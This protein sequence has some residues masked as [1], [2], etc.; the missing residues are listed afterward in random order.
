M[1]TLG[2]ESLRKFSPIVTTALA[3]SH[4][5]VPIIEEVSTS[6]QRHAFVDFAWE[7]NAPDANWC[8]PLKFDALD[9]IN[10][11]K[12]PF[13]RHG[14]ATQFL[15]RRGSQVVGRILVSDDPNF[16]AE[17]Q[18]NI[19][20]FG[21]FESIDDSDVARSLLN[22]AARWL[23]GRGRTGILGPID[24][25]TNYPAGLLVDGFN[26]PQRVMMN[27]NPPYYSELLEN[28]GLRKAKD[29][30]AWWFDAN[31]PA[32]DEWT[33]RANRMM[34]RAGVTIRHLRFED[35]DAEVERCLAVYNQAWES[36]WGFVR[37]TREEFR[38]TACQLKQMAV[39][40]LVLLVEVGSQPVG[41]C[42]TLPDLNEAIRPLNGNLTWCGLPT[43]VVK[44]LRGLKQIKTA[45][46]LTLGILPGFRRRGIAELLILRAF[47]YGAQKLG[48]TGAELSWTLEDNDPINRT[49]ENV[50]AKVYKR[51]RIYE[52]SI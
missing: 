6:R 20:S 16:N 4:S 1:L 15:A 49:I 29:L 35:F 14:A 13:Y 46:M 8:P 47:R 28:W 25:S 34:H 3:G 38:H 36:L 39:P 44:L 37:M 43:G 22:T 2:W 45:R 11:C 48:Y 27:H 26:T 52:R 19:G 9:N 50:G 40:E 32:L 17:H 18:S 30:Y 12:H 23:R 33:A 51:F 10:P 5:K 41:F 24:Y 7:V 21:M 42:V 31:N